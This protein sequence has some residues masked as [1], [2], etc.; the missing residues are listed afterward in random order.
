MRYRKFHIIT[1]Y[2]KSANILKGKVVR[3]NIRSTQN[4][5]GCA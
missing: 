1:H 5:I 2:R 4:K 3:A